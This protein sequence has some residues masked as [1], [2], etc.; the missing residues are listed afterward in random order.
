[1]LSFLLW[2]PVAFGAIGT[3]ILTL[4]GGPGVGHDYLEPLEALADEWPVVFF[5]QLGCGN[6]EAALMR[7]KH[8]RFPAPLGFGRGEIA[9]A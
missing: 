8:L 7:H 2:A 5:D 9:I 3:P 6:S 4:H 1:M